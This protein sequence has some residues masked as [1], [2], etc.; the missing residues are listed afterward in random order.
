[1]VSQ[2]LISI[3]SSAQRAGIIMDIPL[4]A[5]MVLA[6]VWVSYCAI[7]LFRNNH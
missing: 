3:Q 6:T 5:V 2:S 7:D 1:M 4:I